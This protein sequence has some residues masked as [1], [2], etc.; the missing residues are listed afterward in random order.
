M[1]RLVLVM[2]LLL[3]ACGCSDRG[4]DGRAVLRIA[5]WGGAGDGSEFQRVTNE[6]IAAFE[7]ENPGVDVRVEGVPDQ[8]VS[9]M[10]LS[11][12]AGAEPDIMVLDASSAAVFINNG[13]LA[14]L[15]PLIERDPSFRLEDRFENIVD[16]A[17]RGEALYAIPNGFTPLVMYLNRRH[18]REAGVGLP[19]AGWTFDDFLRI[20][21][22][23]TRRNA[24]G[25]TER[26]GFAFSN[27]FP[28]WIPWLWNNGGDVL[29]P[30]GTRVTI[31]TPENAAAMSFLRDLVVRHRVAPSLSAM[32]AMGVDPFASGRA[33][34]TVSGHWAL[35]GFSVAPP[36][37][38]GKPAITLDD[39]EV[40]PLPS[41]LPQPVTVFYESGYAISRNSRQK[42]LAWRFI[43][44]MTSFQARMKLNVTGIEVDARRD[45]TAERARDRLHAQ[46][47]PIIPSARPPWGSKVEGFETVERQMQGAMDSVLQQGTPPEVA[48]ARAQQRVQREFAKRE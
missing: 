29:T 8:Y 36:G 18:F 7:R 38:D 45:V 10:L 17:R 41:N 23:L 48:L 15:T 31:A 33:S 16:I 20:S 14:D 37:P 44:H 46:F 1:R 4:A 22:R 30:D 32:Q 34:M 5:N 42:D 40:V 21:Q 13:V 35:V 25:E 11:Y 27:W 43:A 3:A 12:V 28:G 2:G 24:R 47:L 26:Y 39:L 9:K 6:L 19:R